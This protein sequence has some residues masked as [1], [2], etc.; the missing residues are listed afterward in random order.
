M[1]KFKSLRIRMQKIP[2]TLST[3][4]NTLHIHGNVNCG[5]KKKEF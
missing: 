4:Q 5:K 3:A 2:L 1:W